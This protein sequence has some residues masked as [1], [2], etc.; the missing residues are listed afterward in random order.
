MSNNTILEL[1]GLQKKIGDITEYLRGGEVAPF[2]IN[3]D[4]LNILQLF[5]NASVDCCVTSPPYWG[6][7][8][9]ESEGIGNELKYDIYIDNLLKI[10]DQLYN[11]LKPTGSLWLNLGDT[12]QNKGLI[13]IPWRVALALTQRG[14][15]IRNSVIWN[16][17][18]SGMDNSNDRLRNIHEYVFHLV[19]N[20]KDYY[21][22]VDSVKSD[23]RKSRVVNGAIVSATGVTGI[24]YRRQIELST[25]LSDEEKI[26]AMKALNEV[27]NEVRL[28]SLS[29]FRMVIRGQQ[30]TTHSN[31]TKVSGRAKELVQRGYYFLKYDPKGSKPS[32]VWEILPEDRQM[33][34]THYAP[35]PEDLCVIPILTTCPIDGVVLDP[36]CGTGTTNFVSKSL[37]RRSIGIDVSDEY[38]NFARARVDT[39]L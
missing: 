6:H 1:S 31:S 28:G 5:P 8:E 24:R 20:P 29:D 36:F 37:L 33:R 25:A 10:L 12:Y 7:R 26:D 34:A 35:F 17:I 9:Y 30:R 38:L 11:V 27:L 16:K 4:S 23:P 18:K 22:D 32:D 15:T 14:W 39:L 19:K 2:F 3:G 13:G 21:Y